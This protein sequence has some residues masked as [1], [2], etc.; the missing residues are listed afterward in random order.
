MLDVLLD[1]ILPVLLVAAIGGTVGRKLVSG[2]EA[3]SG[4]V[5]YLFS[6]ALVFT[7]LVGAELGG[8]Q[9]GRIAV[10]AVCVFA[11]NTIAALGW[12]WVRRTDAPTRAAIAITSSVPN[13][14]NMGLPIAALAF[15]A[16]GL[17][18]ATIAFIIGVVMNATTAVTVGA[19]ALGKH[20]MRGAFLAPL[21]YPTLYAAVAGVLLNLMDVELPTVVWEPAITLAAAAIPCMLVV[22]GL[23]FQMPRF[24]DV[25]DSL[26]VSVNRLVVGPL[27][28]WALV[29]V[30]GMGGTAASVVILMAA[31]P[32]AVNTTI[33]AGQLG[34]NTPLAVS[35][36][37]TSTLLS[38]VTLAVL[39]T[40]L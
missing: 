29:S 18:I 39:L 20:T 9:V 12:A 22:L 34:A 26:A 4:L 24:Y 14:G 1:V 30:L 11:V 7:S 25:T 5:F 40:L 23:S 33:L 10:V 8:A 6:P 32:A 35:A 19:H 27:A 38:V 15:G 17:E 2:P 3:L 28:A 13:Q 36:V 21:R 16:A 37:V 31:M